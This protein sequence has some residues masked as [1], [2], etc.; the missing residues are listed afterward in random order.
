MVRRQNGVFPR[1][2]GFAKDGLLGIGQTAGEVQ[3]PSQDGKCYVGIV[4]R[5]EFGHL[6]SFEF[7]KYL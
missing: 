2:K 3:D 5:M 6:V 1:G 4:T 7:D